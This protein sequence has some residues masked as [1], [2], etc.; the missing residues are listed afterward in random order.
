MDIEAI[1]NDGI[2]SLCHIVYVDLVFNCALLFLDCKCLLLVEALILT[3]DS[4]AVWHVGWLADNAKVVEAVNNGKNEIQY[5][6]VDD[7]SN[8]CHI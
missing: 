8:G 1:C 3:I 4:P 7:A 6:V 5:Y 2:K